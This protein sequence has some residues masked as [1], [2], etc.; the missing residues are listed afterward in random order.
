MMMERL[1]S[2]QQEHEL[3]TKVVRKMEQLVLVK[4]ENEQENEEI[5]RIDE[6]R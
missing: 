1:W 2:L 3:Q 4:Y 5:E 6:R